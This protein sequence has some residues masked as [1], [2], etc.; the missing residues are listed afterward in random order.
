[1]VS[2][3]KGSLPPLVPKCALRSIGHKRPLDEAAT[4]ALALLVGVVVT[5]NAAHFE[6]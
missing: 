4:A 2:A 3:A 5:L 6:I 1:V